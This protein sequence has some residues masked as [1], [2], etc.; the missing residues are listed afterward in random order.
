MVPDRMR[1][2]TREDPIVLSDDATGVLVPEPAAEVIVVEDVAL[3]EC[4][5]CHKAF[6]LSR[7]ALHVRWC[8]QHGGV[9]EDDRPAMRARRV[10]E[11]LKQG[12][13]EEEEDR[14]AKR[15]RRVGELLMAKAG[16]TGG[17]L[18]KRGDG[19]T[20]PIRVRR[21]AARKGLGHET[22]HFL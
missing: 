18:G 22:S 3:D 11:L 16:Y 8:R 9:E 20:C 7:F 5:M 4:P 17:G 21:L 13:E 14:P 12:V 15:A 2:S 19:P 1:G 10:G 6:P